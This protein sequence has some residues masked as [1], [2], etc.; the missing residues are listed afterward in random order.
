MNPFSK[1]KILILF[2]VLDIYNIK[3]GTKKKKIIPV[4][5]ILSLKIMEILLRENKVILIFSIK[6]YHTEPLITWP[7]KANF[8]KKK[9]IQSKTDKVSLTVLFSFFKLLPYVAR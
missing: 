4:F 9:N 6:F 2:T 1:K 7:H 8:L 3:V 5:W